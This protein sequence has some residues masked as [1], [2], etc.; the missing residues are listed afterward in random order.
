AYSMIRLSRRQRHQPVSNPLGRKNGIKI[1]NVNGRENGIILTFSKAASFP[2]W[3]SNSIVSNC[4]SASASDMRFCS[5][6]ISGL[7]KA[8]I[9]CSTSHE[10]IV[11]I[12][13]N[14]CGRI[15]PEVFLSNR[16]E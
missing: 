2:S 7:L 9:L 4:T 15:N 1:A 12:T 13:D 11:Q 10:R 5:I 14:Y 8:I 16:N 6:L 3:T